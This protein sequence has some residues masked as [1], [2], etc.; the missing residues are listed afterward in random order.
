MATER[1]ALLARLNAKPDKVDEV[2]DF[3]ESALPLAEDEDFTVS[4]YALQIDD[5]TFG[6]FDT[7]Q[8]EAG[9]Q[10]HLDGDIAAALMEKA[11]DLLAEP[12]T[13]EKVEVLAHK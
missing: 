3:L 10:A 12:P 11:D 2:R 13:I 7:A 4:C 8:D 9:R 6:I 5:T 1:K